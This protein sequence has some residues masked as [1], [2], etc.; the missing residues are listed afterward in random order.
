MMEVLSKRAGSCYGGGK[1][2]AR[3]EQVWG[4]RAVEMPKQCATHSVEV[5][6]ALKTCHLEKATAEECET[7]HHAKAEAERELRQCD[8]LEGAA[9]SWT[10]CY[11]LRGGSKIK[12]IFSM[13]LL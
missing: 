7:I 9:Q 1:T 2:V 6:W 11:E 3:L 10:W 13:H 4:Y 8:I 12:L 5:T